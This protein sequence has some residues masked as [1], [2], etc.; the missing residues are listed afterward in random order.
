MTKDKHYLFLD[1]SGTLP[2]SKD[3]VIV[4]AAVGFYSPRKIETIIKSVRKKGKFKKPVGELK[5]Y[6]VGEKS[7]ELFFRKIVAE[8]FDIFILIVEKMGRKISD[9]PEHFAI[10][11]GLLIKEAISFYSKI[12]QIIFD[13]HYHRDT[14][15]TKFNRV[16]RDFLNQDLP[17]IEHV[18]SQKDKKVNVADMVAGAVLAKET[19]KNYTFYEIFKERIISEMRLN[20]PEAKRRLFCR[21]KNLPEP[22]QTPIQGK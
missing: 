1:E 18:D 4:V 15:I 22:V 7:K 2:D 12:E 14:D 8:N 13:R 9:T 5:F 20:W 19:G 16:L 17:S 11:S 10:L 6:N 21:I 3:K